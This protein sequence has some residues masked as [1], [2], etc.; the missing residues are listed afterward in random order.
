MKLGD[1]FVE[2]I[3]RRISSNGFDA[4]RDIDP[5]LFDITFK[6]LNEAVEKGF[7]S[8]EYG[9]DDAYFVH[10]IKIQQC[11]I[12]SFQSTQRTE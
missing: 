3:L 6:W 1:D 10:Q 12:R 7:G 8:V 11:R 4:R 2:K 9:T 5:D